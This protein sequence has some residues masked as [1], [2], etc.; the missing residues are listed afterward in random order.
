[1]VLRAVGVLILALAR[2]LGAPPL[3]LKAPTPP[4]KGGV[5]RNHSLG[6]AR[7]MRAGMPWPLVRLEIDIILDET[8]IIGP[9][10]IRLAWHS[11]GTYDPG[12]FPHGGS[13]GATMRFAPEKDYA[14]NRGLEEAIEK[15]DP[16]YEQF[17]GAI[18]NSDLWIFAAYLATEW[19][20]GPVIEFVP[21][22]VDDT[23]PCDCPPEDRLPGWDLSECATPAS[24]LG[25]GRIVA[26]YYRSSTLYQI[27]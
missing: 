1:M 24:G 8:P 4:L 3:G 6:H 21:G 10:F 9:R 16:I 23:P 13:N 11:A 14:D 2:C 5:A 25:F 19:V 27:H 17:G 26:L 12:N 18:S 20:G 15:L 7:D 22:R